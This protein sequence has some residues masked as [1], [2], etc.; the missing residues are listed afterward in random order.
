M[1]LNPD[2]ADMIAGARSFA[3]RA[4]A[5]SLASSSKNAAAMV[6]NVRQYVV[7]APE[8]DALFSDAE[9]ACLQL[10]RADAWNPDQVSEAKVAVYA[11]LSD[12]RPHL[13]RAEPNDRAKAVGMDWWPDR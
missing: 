11:A 9:R 4:D 1:P 8:L 3:E 13:D 5:V 7:P 12:L 2:L 6:Q 10:G